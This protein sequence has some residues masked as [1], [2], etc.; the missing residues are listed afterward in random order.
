MV[1]VNLDKPAAGEADGVGEGST[2]TPAPLTY[3]PN[4]TTATTRTMTAL[5]RAGANLGM[6][7]LPRSARHPTCCL[8]LRVRSKV[9]LRTR[10]ETCLGASASSQS[11][12]VW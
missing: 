7:N 11:L 12:I 6:L 10:S 8:V 4:A 9:A 5:A 1:E 3:M 2:P